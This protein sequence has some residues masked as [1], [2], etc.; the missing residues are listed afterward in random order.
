MQVNENSQNHLE[1]QLDLIME[2]LQNIEEMI[3]S[4][5]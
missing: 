3:K 4:K 5:K 1:E 2:R